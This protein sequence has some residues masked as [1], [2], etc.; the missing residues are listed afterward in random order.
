MARGCGGTGGQ[1]EEEKE[2]AR[3]SV[4]VWVLRE[5]TLTLAPRLP[6]DRK[7]ESG[8]E[9]VA[10][11]PPE[12]NARPAAGLFFRRA[13]REPAWKPQHR[14]RGGFAQRRP[15]YVRPP[16]RRILTSGTTRPSAAPGTTGPPMRAA[17]KHPG[18]R[19]VI[20]VGAFTFDGRVWQRGGPP[21]PHS[22]EHG[23]ATPTPPPK[24]SAAERPA[25]RPAG[26]DDV[27]PGYRREKRD[28][29]HLAKSYEVYHAPDG[30][31]LKSKP[32]TWVHYKAN[33]KRV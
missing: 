18:F 16:S 4:C 30:A 7:S 10:F 13:Y 28:A 32:Q 27:P 3:V 8:H 20:G 17:G 1:S 11:S 26:H 2:R 9:N 29:P 23:Y 5:G 33:R 15:A 25:G 12:G 31:V 24:P 6:C 21:V 14:A 22:Q 19:T